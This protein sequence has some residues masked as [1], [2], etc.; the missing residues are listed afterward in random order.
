MVIVNRIQG[1]QRRMKLACAWN[2]IHFSGRSVLLLSISTRRPA[3]FKNEF[4]LQA[5]QRS[6]ATVC[7]RVWRPTTTFERTE[8]EDPPY[9]DEDLFLIACII[10]AEHHPIRT[11]FAGILEQ[12]EHST[13]F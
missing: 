1:F 9:I 8:E 4:F 6:P 10:C 3:I 7:W 5:M 11:V 12:Y 2:R 13:N